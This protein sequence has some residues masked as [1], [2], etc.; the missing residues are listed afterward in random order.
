M[1]PLPG[2]GLEPLWLVRLLTHPSVKKSS[3]LLRQ[4]REWPTPIS[5]KINRASGM[6][7]EVTQLGLQLYSTY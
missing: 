3:V 4:V 5:Q 2:S 7:A 1:G 6:A